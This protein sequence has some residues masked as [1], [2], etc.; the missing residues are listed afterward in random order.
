MLW[1]LSVNLF[2]LFGGNRCGITLGCGIA[3]T[4]LCFFG[5]IT[6]DVYAMVTIATVGAY[7]AGRTTQSVREI[8]AGSSETRTSSHG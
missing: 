6:G 3:T 5:K 1:G 2:Q 7:I 4:L 8:G